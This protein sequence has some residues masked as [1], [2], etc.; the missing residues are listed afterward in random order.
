MDAEKVRL[1]FK[2]A[3]RAAV[4]I[5]EPY[6]GAIVTVATIAEALADEAIAQETDGNYTRSHVYA[7]AAGQLRKAGT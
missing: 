7:W 6:M 2:E 1:Q 4:H 5:T 3:I